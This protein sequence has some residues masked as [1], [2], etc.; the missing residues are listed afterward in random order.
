M[1]LE[2]LKIFLD[3]ATLKSISK[4][5]QKSHLTQSALSQQ[6][7]SWE[8]TLGTELLH[9]SNKGANLTDAG[10]IAEKYAAQ[11]CKLYDDMITEINHLKPSQHC[12]SI[13][14]IPEVCNYALPCTLYEVKKQFP[15]C[16]I[17][18]NEG[19]S[20]M[21]E[22][23]ILLEEGD[24]GF[25]SGPSSNPELSSYKVFAD[26]VMLVTSGSTLCPDEINLNEL[27]R[28]PLIWSAQLC[29]VHKAINS[30]LEQELNLNILYN[31]DSIE[32]VKLAAVKG[33]GAA[34]LPYM[35]I[36]KELYSKQL[37]IINIDQFQIYNEV[38]MIKKQTQRCDND[39]KQL[40]RYI[41]KTLIDTLC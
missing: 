24:I 33:H 9:R 34:F 4:A 14:A 15:Q 41:E 5:A 35:S 22:E 7:K 32:A 30:T 11:I 20:S 37:K 31:L 36:K 13:Y 3:I 19:S 39:T 1:N 23:R 2:S 8:N 10:I 38:Y 21:I 28:Y 25:I 29:C 6:L 12:L 27:P 26:K 17:S 16:H 18:L 40:L